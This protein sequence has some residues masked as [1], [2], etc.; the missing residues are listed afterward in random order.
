MN[1]PHWQ[2]FPR[3]SLTEHAT[4]LQFAAQLSTGRATEVTARIQ[5]EPATLQVLL[6]LLGSPSTKLS[7]RIGI[8]VVMEDLAGTP[9]L[10]HVI[11]DLGKLAMHRKASIRAD[12]C[13]YLGLTHDAAA[14][15]F[16]QNCLQDPEAEVREVAED[17][18]AHLKNVTL[19]ST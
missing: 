5:Q 7:V 15:P 10:R 4:D 16:L 2:T 1:T 17:A 19:S 18:L 9:V 8:G 11:P 14:H 12:A 6:K 13:H 3:W